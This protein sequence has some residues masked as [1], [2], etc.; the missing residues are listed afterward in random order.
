MGALA[1]IGAVTNFSLN[2]T[3][4]DSP[5]QPEFGVIASRL[6]LEHMSKSRCW[7]SV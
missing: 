4:F 3:V 2:V 5:L 1:G 7:S 6:W